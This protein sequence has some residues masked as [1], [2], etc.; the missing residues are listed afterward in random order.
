M[1]DE[2]KTPKTTERGHWKG[3]CVGSFKSIALLEILLVVL[4]NPSLNCGVELFHL[5]TVNSVGEDGNE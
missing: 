4:I 2:K 5:R 3:N 1:D